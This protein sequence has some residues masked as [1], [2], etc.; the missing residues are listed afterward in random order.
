MAGLDEVID[1]GGLH[2]VERSQKEVVDDQQV[3]GDQAAKCHLMAGVQAA[4]LQVLEQLEF[5]RAGGG[6]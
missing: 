5:E 4:R 3:N 1:V 2:A 6:P